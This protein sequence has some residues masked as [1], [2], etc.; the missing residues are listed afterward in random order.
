MP[1]PPPPAPAATPHG[2]RLAALAIVVGLLLALLPTAT[3]AQTSTAGWVLTSFCT[4]AEDYPDARRFRVR[5]PTQTT[6]QVTLRNLDT[7]TD[8][9]VTAPPGDSFH[10]VPAGRG[11]NTTQLL[12]G[13][14]LAQTKAA[15]NRACATLVGN[16]ECLP[17]EGRYRVTWQLANNDT[18]PR[19]IVATDPAG[20]VFEPTTVPAGG[21]A[22][23][24][25]LVDAPVSGT[26]DRT[27]EVTVDLG[28]AVISRP[29]ATVTLGPCGA[30]IPPSAAVEFTKVA[31]RATAVEGEEVTYT[32][33]ATNTG[34]VALEILQL[35]DDRLGVFVDAPDLEPLGLGETITYDRSYVM[36]AED[37]ALG[38]KVNHAVL[39]VVAAEGPA[40]DPFSA[41]ASA[42][43]ELTEP[44][45]APDVS[46]RGN[47]L[48]L[49][50]E[51]EYVVTWSLTNTGAGT[52]AV[53]DASRDGLVF[54]P[55][56]LPPGVTATAQERVPGTGG[57]VQTLEL[58]VT[59]QPEDPQAE[60]L[61]RSTS[62]T[63]GRCE[64]PADGVA[65]TFDKVAD[66]AEAA[67]GE[68]V[69]YT[70][71]GTNTGALPLELLALVDDRLG[72]VLDGAEV[73]IVEPG[74]TVTGTLSYV[75]TDAD[76][77]IGE[78][79]NI[80]VVTVSTVPEPGDEAEVLSAVAEAQVVTDPIVDGE[81]PDEPAEPDEPDEPTEVDDAAEEL[82]ETGAPTSLVELAALALG[83]W[84]AGG[85]L[86]RRRPGPLPDLPT[87][88]SGPP[89]AS[90]PPV[91]HP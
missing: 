51:R 54:D 26:A 32:Y 1:V 24:E 7:G 39:T 9:A 64:E 5:N 78:I 53:V 85:L 61:V 13:G 65:F 59:V 29:T 2:P 40:Q 62:L 58:T 74:E 49:P 8:T 60:P 71:T 81:D 25:E 28:A 77:N 14:Q 12:V 90:P 30:P 41:V 11:S 45:T 19:S 31:D 55:D 91:R 3:S 38:T 87:T 86:L 27:V 37:V 82:P 21:R 44:P 83:F 23:A 16:A 48:C 63:I 57:P 72:L 20:V 15:N 73:G 35:K 76:A 50:D 84:L 33:A 79:D 34:E 10:L 88:R 68:T 18:S 22:V 89:R 66:R 42:A 17:D 80:A 56:P 70:Y 36:T 43:V 52:D 6:E 67:V 69:V 46:L 4:A 47:A 75:V